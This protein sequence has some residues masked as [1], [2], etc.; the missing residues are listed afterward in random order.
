MIN[1][2]NPPEKC[3]GHNLSSMV[4]AAFTIWK[5]TQQYPNLTACILKFCPTFTCPHCGLGSSVGGAL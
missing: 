1:P 3:T 2:P 4:A 5:C